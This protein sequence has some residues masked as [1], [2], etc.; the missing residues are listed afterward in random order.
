[1]AKLTPTPAKM[2]SV[3]SKPRVTRMSCPA[4]KQF[5][6]L[7]TMTVSIPKQQRQ[8]IN[9]FE[10]RPCDI[11]DVALLPYLD[12]DQKGG[13]RIDCHFSK[14]PKK[15]NAIDEQNEVNSDEDGGLKAVH[16]CLTDYDIRKSNAPVD[17]QLADLAR[18]VLL[19]PKTKVIFQKDDFSYTYVCGKDVYTNVELLIRNIMD[20]IKGLYGI[21][22][23]DKTVYNPEDDESIRSTESVA[24]SS[25][26]SAQP[27][28]FSLLEEKSAALD[29]ILAF[30]SFLHEPNFKMTIL[31]DS[32]FSR[33]FPFDYN[34]EKDEEFFR[35][36]SDV[37]VVHTWYDRD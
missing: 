18:Y 15:E 37:D 17:P 13:V 16:S 34:V 21:K 7:T 24:E 8:V 33:V 35:L 25:D 23:S 29:S 22:L 32:G 9:T 19:S 12:M 10:C 3:C 14:K 2:A 27:Q 1:M 28:T 5:A 20:E 30:D 36:D 6:T 11:K 4:C 31:D 26:R